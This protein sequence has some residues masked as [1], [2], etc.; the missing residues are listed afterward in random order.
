MRDIALVRKKVSVLCLRTTQRHRS[1]I[2]FTRQFSKLCS[3]L[4]QN[5]ISDKLLCCESERNYIH[6]KSA[7]LLHTSSQQLQKQQRPWLPKQQQQG[8][9]HDFDEEVE[10]LSHT[11]SDIGWV[12]VDSLWDSF[13]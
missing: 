10:I 13:R 2:P 11:H 8:F 1:L 7:S 6:L 3:P 9:V 12:S 5:S 4:Q